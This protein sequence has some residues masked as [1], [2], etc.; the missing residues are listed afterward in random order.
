MVHVSNIMWRIK[1]QPSNSI[2][3]SDSA[4]HLLVVRAYYIEDFKWRLHFP[5]W[6][7]V[8]KGC[9]E[10]GLF[11]RAKLHLKGIEDFNLKHWFDAW[12]WQDSIQSSN[13]WVLHPSSLYR[14]LV[15]SYHE[16][17]FT[18]RM[19][20]MIVDSKSTIINILL[21][22]HIWLLFFIF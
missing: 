13:C 12:S 16:F 14:L 10:R 19:I 9:F 20:S 18:I 21:T 4:G 7:C 6:G 15:V 8:A 17:S 11:W 2:S 22:V 5:I 3:C 1:N